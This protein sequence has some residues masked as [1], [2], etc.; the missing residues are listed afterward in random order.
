MKTFRILISETYGKEI[1]IKAKTEKQAIKIFEEQGYN[2]DQV[3]RE[4]FIDAMFCTIE[5][6]SYD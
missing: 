3:H 2:D 4:K 1:D 6:I 5:E